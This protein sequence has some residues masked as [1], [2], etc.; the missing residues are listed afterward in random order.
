VT[1]YQAVIDAL[2][3]GGFGPGKREGKETRYRCPVHE[4]AGDHSPSLDVSEGQ[5]GRA[6]LQCRSAHCKAEDILR[7]LKPERNGHTNGAPGKPRIVA[8]YDYRDESGNLLCQTVRYD[9]KNFKQRQPDGHG[10]WKWNLKEVRRIPY[11]LQE[12]LAA[13]IE[14]AVYVCEGEKDVDGLA[15]LGF[16]ATTNP[17]GAGKWGHLDSTTV[18]KAFRGRRVVILPDNDK[19]GRDHANDVALSLRTIAAEI[20]VLELPGVPE[21]GDVSDW[22]ARGGTADQLGHLIEKNGIRV[23][24]ESNRPYWA[25]EDWTPESEDL[26]CPCG[27]GFI[28]GHC[29]KCHD[30]G[31]TPALTQHK[32]PVVISKLSRPEPRSFIW[33]GFLMLDSI[34]LLSALWKV[35]KTTLLS[36]L[37]LAL[38]RGGEF[39]GLSIQQCS[40]LYVTEEAVGEWIDRRDRLGIG[41]HV[42]LLVQPWSQKPMP[43]DWLAWLDFLKK[44]CDENRI[45][46]VIFDTLSAVWPIR[47][48]NDA[49]EVQA[50]L[51][52]LRE[53]ANGRA[54]AVVHHLRKFDN[55][56]GTGT[57]GSGA[58]M[59]FVEVI[60]EM[61]RFGDQKQN[62]GEDDDDESDDDR[63]RVLTSVSRWDE[64]PKKIVIRLNDD[65]TDYVA[66][67]DGNEVRRKQLVAA[68]LPL[69]PSEAP[70]IGATEVHEQLPK[71]G[72][73]QRS[74]VMKELQSGAVRGDWQAVGAGTKGSPR[75]FWRAKT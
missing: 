57:R 67:G 10:G 25:G 49:G 48:E 34:S 68:L 30:S 69:L 72:R 19:R 62:Q 42:H 75:T 51:M 53:L 54:I 39:L 65:G 8:T 11:R 52:P 21:K 59:G 14:T 13:P 66:E 24:P 27:S 47:N 56:D 35:G 5:G 37:L 60:T 23:D 20:I 63:R 73:P 7:I 40:V 61:R 17:M 44:Y 9:P 28:K 36:R 74:K 3:R 12:L 32:M 2:D 55:G 16:I 26:R 18:Q 50:A 4:A 38:G 41:D 43:A 31:P 33:Y 29:T 15:R 46:V 64:T 58:L 71:Q 6:L 70:G 1:E 22:I 45:K